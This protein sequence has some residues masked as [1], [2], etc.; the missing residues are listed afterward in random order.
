MQALRFH[1]SRCVR[2]APLSIAKRAL[3]S[4]PSSSSSAPSNSLPW[5]IDPADAAPSTSTSTPSHRIT[6]HAYP[7]PPLPAG[8]SSDSPIAHLR[9]ALST[10]PHLEPGQLIVREPIPTATGPPLPDSPPKGRRKRGR[11]YAGEGVYEYA[12]GIWNWIIIAQVKEGTEKRGAI[13][14]VVR[15]VRRTLLTAQPPLPLP[16]NSKRRVND[17]W[18]MIDAG[19][20]AVHIVGKE[21]REKFFPDT[22]RDW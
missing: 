13:E 3:S 7:L 14:S 2:R 10:S 21:A 6:P 8:V 5:F 9:A 20:F 4:I 17:G 12:G 15:I 16:P 22:V 18:A 1:T 11:T 19:E